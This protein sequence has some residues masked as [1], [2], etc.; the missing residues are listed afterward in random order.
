MVKCEKAALILFL[1]YVAREVNKCR[2]LE[3]AKDVLRKLQIH[4]MNLGAEEIER[5]LFG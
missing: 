5:E 3:C 4:I 1:Q 2:D